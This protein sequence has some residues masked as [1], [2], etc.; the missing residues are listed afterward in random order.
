MFNHTP[1]GR[2]F[3]EGMIDRLLGKAYLT[4]K[5]VHEKLGVIEG[6]PS[7]EQLN[8]VKE[9]YEKD[10]ADVKPY[11]DLGI[12]GEQ[13]PKTNYSISRITAALV[14]AESYQ[15]AVAE[16]IAQFDNIAA[17]ADK[18]KDV[19]IVSQHTEDIVILREKLSVLE[20]IVAN[21]K[22]LLAL[23]DQVKDFNESLDET[24]KVK[25]AIE[26]DT[27]DEA[28]H[29]KAAD[30]AITD[31]D[32]N[33]IIDTY[34]VKSENLNNITVTGKA[35]GHGTRIG[36]DLNI[37]VTSVISALGESLVFAPKGDNADTTKLY[38]DLNKGCLW[39]YD[40]AKQE[41]KNVILAA[42]QAK[43]LA[44][45]AVATANSANNT[46]SAAKTAAD[47]AVTTAD[48]ANTTATTAK[49]TADSA[50]EIANQAKTKADSAT[51]ISTAAKEA[52]DN[53]VAEFTSKYKAATADDLGLVK[54]DA[55]TI[56]IT[57]EG[58]ISCN[59]DNIYDNLSVNDANTHNM[60]WRGKD[61][62]ANFDN[63][64]FSA[65]VADGSFKD[66]F[67]GDYITKTVTIS[68]KAYTC[69]F[70]VGHLDYFFKFPQ[71]ANGNGE[72]TQWNNDTHHV[73]IFPETPFFNAQMNSQHTTNGGY[74]G[75]AMFNQTLPAVQAGLSQVFTLVPFANYLTNSLDTNLTSGAGASRTGGA[76]ESKWYTR[77]VELFSE[78]MAFGAPSWQT[79][80][81]YSTP[82]QIAAFRLNRQLLHIKDWWWW[83][84]DIAS[85]SEF[86]YCHYV[87]H[88]APGGAAASGG[89][90]PF[91]LIK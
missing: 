70:I 6:L 2:N 15:T 34:T 10:T 63:G 89:C 68:G 17:V 55:K 5:E 67:I 24:G 33:N 85:S 28:L 45:N 69:K 54:P 21:L 56:L 4:V 41:W 77:Y 48:G 36:N 86:C 31:A 11:I 37:N 47:N 44:N 91:C 19:E 43:T 73:L 88:S 25:A 27:A 75:S 59:S 32:G 84:R 20:T 82:E 42:A 87:G 8:A 49:N 46:A 74:A 80:N 3:N 61:I 9:L 35:T 7:R 71:I 29:A 30:L 39:A 23:R 50:T 52:S 12:V 53:A 57:S 65:A 79:V 38:V 78:K 22:D 62:T 1:F 72:I 16:V 64:S 83:L 40:A 58:V 26:S 76:Y 60:L 66:I 14:L 51:E 90:R 81:A 18:A 13:A